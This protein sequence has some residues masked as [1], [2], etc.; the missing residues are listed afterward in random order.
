MWHGMREPF[1]VPVRVR[2]RH[3]G[4]GFGLKSLFWARNRGVT[5]TG[6]SVAAM[7][8]FL[9]DLPRARNGIGRFQKISERV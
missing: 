4:G 2:A 9:T 1:R 5:I 8:A 7:G 6:R 3:V